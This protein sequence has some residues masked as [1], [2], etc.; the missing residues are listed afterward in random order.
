MKVILE[1]DNELNVIGIA[2]NGHEVMQICQKTKPDLILMDIVMPVCDGVET[3]RLVKEKYNDIK[4]II[5]TTFYEEVYVKKALEYGADGF[6]LKDVKPA[7]LIITIKGTINGLR[8]FHQDVFKTTVKLYVTHNKKDT[9]SKKNLLSER[10]EKILKLIVFGKSNKEIAEN[11]FLSEGR[12]KNIISEILR[13]LNLKDR[14]QLAIYAVKN[15]I[16]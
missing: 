10:D 6:I 3:T 9:I 8:I 12:V 16:V 11:I 2:S 1:N 13:K 7:D 15:D 5:L 14:T 4:I